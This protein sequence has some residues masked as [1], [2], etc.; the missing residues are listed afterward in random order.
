MRDEDRDR[1]IN[2]LTRRGFEVKKS[3][4]FRLYTQEGCEVSFEVMKTC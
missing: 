2:E 4:Y 1:V 3:G